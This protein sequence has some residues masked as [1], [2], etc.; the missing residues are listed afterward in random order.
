MISHFPKSIYDFPK[1]IYQLP[2]MIYAAS[3]NG[4]SAVNVARAVGGSLQNPGAL[5]PT[6]K[7]I[8]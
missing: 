8:H 3:H 4:S 7:S 2:K 1:V 6:D 5:N